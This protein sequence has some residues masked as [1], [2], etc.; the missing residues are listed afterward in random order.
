VRQLPQVVD[1]SLAVFIIKQ[2]GDK[3]I[4]S[5]GDQWSCT[6]NVVYIWVDYLMPLMMPIWQ[7]L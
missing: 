1:D 2:L 6:N 5:K 4:E 7:V 3:T